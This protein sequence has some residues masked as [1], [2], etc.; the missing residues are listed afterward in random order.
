M[1]NL[2]NSILIS[3]N[4]L[5]ME[6]YILKH[7]ASI[8]TNDNILKKVKKYEKV[9]LDYSFK[10]TIFRLPTN[11]I[12]LDICT[13]NKI[14]INYLPNS[15]KYLNIYIQTSNTYNQCVKYLPRELILLCNISYKY[16]SYI[17]DYLPPTLNKFRLY[18][19]TR[20]LMINLPIYLI[21]IN[22]TLNINKITM[23]NIPK[24]TTYIIGMN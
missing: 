15:I 18:M 1:N 3:T 21:L 10:N 17:Y 9:I 20:N 19:D 6:A 5:N 22:I 8:D 14:N 13:K 7:D 11:V 16:K 23:E 12:T 2:N 24:Y 4:Y